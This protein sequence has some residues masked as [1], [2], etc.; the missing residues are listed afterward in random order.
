[1]RIN[2]GVKMSPAMTAGI[3]MMLWIMDD[4]M[5]LI[6]ATAPAPKSAPPTKGGRLC[7][8][9]YTTRSA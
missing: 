3:S 6:D 8:L 1:V 9:S 5:A 2:K 7:N 4:I